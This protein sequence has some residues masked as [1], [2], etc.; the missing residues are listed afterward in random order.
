[1][2]EKNSQLRPHWCCRGC[3]GLVLLELEEKG[4]PFAQVQLRLTKELG[5]NWE[6][7]PVNFSTQGSNN[8]SSEDTV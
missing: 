1:M 5:G 4:E 7:S 8:G 2:A 3:K 6:Q